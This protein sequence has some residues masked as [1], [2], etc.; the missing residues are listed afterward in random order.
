MASSTLAR[1]KGFKVYSL[2]S[3]TV[4]ALSAALLVVA[5]VS[6]AT[7]A[8][9]ASSVDPQIAAFMVPLT[10]LVLVMMIEVGRVAL[11]G[12]LPAEAPQRRRSGPDKAARHWR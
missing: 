2:V 4:A 5:G 6:P 3:V 1:R 9:L 8:S 11:R 12:N 10:L 7:A